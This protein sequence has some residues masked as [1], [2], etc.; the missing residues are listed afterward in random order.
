ML[1]WPMAKSYEFPGTW[2]GAWNWGPH[3]YSSTLIFFNLSYKYN[4]SQEIDVKNQKDDFCA[5]VLFSLDLL[6]FI[7]VCFVVF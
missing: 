3:C 4:Y 6:F 1:P 5:T 7:I 2:G